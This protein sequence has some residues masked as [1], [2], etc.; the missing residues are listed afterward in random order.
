MRVRLILPRLLWPDAAAASALRALAL[1]GLSDLLARAKAQPLPAASLE[2]AFAAPFGAAAGTAPIRRAGENDALPAPGSHWLCADPVSLHFARDQMVLSDPDALALTDDEA[3]QLAPALQ[4]ALAEVGAFAFAVPTRGY[5]QLPGPVS[6]TFSSLNDVAGR[7]VALFLP[8]GDAAL[9]WGRIVNAVQIVLHDHP[10][11][12]AREAEGRLLANS[13]WFWGPGC[14]PTLKTPA[15]T[16]LTDAC[17]GRGLA[18]LAGVPDAPLSALA[19]SL[20]PGHDELLILC[21]ALHAPALYGDFTRWREQ[22]GALETHVFAPL[23]ATFKDGRIDRL[24]LEAPGERN[25][26]AFHIT[27]RRWVF[28]LKPRTLDCLATPS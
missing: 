28:W 25:G 16:V 5:L 21:E 24:R 12:R 2:A 23:A 6:A 19:D 14:V 8:E 10:V 7:P 27:R 18:R 9:Q 4:E 15:R 3:A 1:P 13:L 26:R 17:F 20:V 22:L 11:N